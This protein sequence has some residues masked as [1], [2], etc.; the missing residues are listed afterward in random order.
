MS[1]DSPSVDDDSSSRG[2]CIPIDV[3]VHHAQQETA[4]LPGAKK[5]AGCFLS[6]TRQRNSLPGARPGGTRQIKAS[7]KAAFAGCRARGKF[8]RR[9]KL[10]FAGC[11]P[12]GK[13]WPP[14]KVAGLTVASC[15]HALPGATPLGTRQR[16]FFLN[17]FAG[18]PM[19]WHP[20]K[21]SLPGALGGTRQIIIFFLF[22]DPIF[23]WG[24]AT[25]NRSIF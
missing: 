17:F 9:Q 20:A 4:D 13:I 2:D 19:T 7:G 18:C 25:V 12:L 14:A 23:L 5:F 6:G 11:R 16:I 1:T 3:T 15:R 24:L 21:A 22:F 10:V 8:Q